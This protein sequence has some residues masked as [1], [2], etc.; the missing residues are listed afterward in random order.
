MCLNQPHILAENNKFDGSHYYTWKTL[1]TI[2]ARCQG[3]KGYLDGTITRPTE[4]NETH[5][6]TDWYSTTPSLQEW[7]IR[8]AWTTGLIL[9]NIK[10]LDLLINVNITGSA[11]DIWESI[12][13]AGTYE[14][15]Y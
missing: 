15:L 7:D 8:D 10:N 11:A 13:K 14:D 12:R 3:V 9:Y 4:T 1:I 6:P 5:E 2:A